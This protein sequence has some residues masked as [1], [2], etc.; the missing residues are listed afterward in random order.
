MPSPAPLCSDACI[1]CDLDGYI[2][3]NVLEFPW[4][5][6]PTFCAP[7]FHSINWLGFIAGTPSITLEITTFNCQT[8]EGLQAQIYR[9]ADC[10]SWVPV[11]GCDPAFNY[12]TLTATGLQPGE[13]CFL[14]IDGNGGDICDFRVDVVSGLAIAPDVEGAPQIDGPANFC[15]G[16][17][18]FYTAGNVTGAAAYTWTLN[19]SIISYD[20][21]IW[22]YG[23]P[24]GAYQLCVEPSNPCFGPGQSACRDITVSPLPL[25]LV[26]EEVCVEDL[27]FSYG[28]LVFSTPGSYTFSYPRPDGCEQTVLLN[29]T[30]LGPNPPTLINADI[31]HGEAFYLGNQAFTSTGPY[32]VVLT[33]QNGCDSLIELN[34]TVHPPSFTS[35]GVVAAELPFLVGNVAVDTT[36]LFDVILADRFGCDSIILGFLAAIAPDTLF[37]D[38]TICQGDNVF[39]NMDTLVSS[40]VYLDT[41]ISS[42]TAWIQ[43][44]NLT[45][46]PFRDTTLNVSLCEGE[47]IVVGG[48]AYS[49]TGQYRD[50][51]TAANGCDSLVTLNLNVLQPTDTIPAAICEGQ[52]Y[53][54]GNEAYTQPGNYDIILTSPTG[55]Q[56]MVQLQ[57]TVLPVPETSLIE[58]ICEGE[59]LAV[60]NST[61]TTSGA[62]SDTLTAANG[63]DSIVTLNLE[64]IPVPETVL[65]EQICEG[66]TYNIGG[67]VLEMP[68]TYQ[69][70]F[71][72]PQTGCDS[73]VTINLSVLPDFFT[74][75]DA[76]IC[77]GET[78]PFGGVDLSQPGAYQEVY[79]A[80]NGCDSVVVL[81][82]TVNPVVEA[83]LDTTLC[84]GQ[85]LYL[86]PYIFREPVR[87][88]LQFAGAGGCDSLVAL[89][90]EFYD[91]LRVDTAI[92][93]PDEGD[94]FGG[95]IS[96][97]MAG[98]TPPY[99]Y[100]WS[101]SRTDPYIDLLP[102]GRYFLIV[103]DAAGCQEGFYFKVPLEEA[104]PGIAPPIR[105]PGG[106]IQVAPNP[107]R[108][109]LQVQL[110]GVDEGLPVR[111][112]LYNFA[113][114]L[115]FEERAFGLRHRLRP[116]AQAGMYWLVVEQEGVRI[117]V[118]RVVRVEE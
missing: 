77:E 52:S 25:E 115:V 117:G 26:N 2:G 17:N 102:S 48:T 66:G 21:H 105:R 62:Y 57:L 68:G 106:S 32:A 81:N 107:F 61:Y 58:S 109:E 78:Y 103:A 90:L 46:L 53:L 91:S 69:I 72:N 73:L 41:L 118:E 87:E 96:V 4:E 95:S 38:S 76:A 65:D 8:G 101:D 31:C 23:L 10:S 50:T 100:L 116:G 71:P 35:L 43:Q 36:G 20:K 60:G 44:L 88:A 93:E 113:G 39:Y 84:P 114:Q 6:P 70:T 89:N 22:L 3:R 12:T 79:A 63:C 33:D 49:S 45:V 51:L 83:A 85:A 112:L 56:S 37:T 111:L 108:R 14:V 75:M 16:E 34:L 29:L 15:P 5:A 59:S 11:S 74:Q 54:L 110:T 7:Q 28:G 98:G 97:E 13:T 99:S 30:V 42:D 67:Q 104:G 92:I 86:G 24:A 64:V 82:L 9:T 27:P 94:F 55:C 40:G 18:A 80:G 1:L 19:D 47:E